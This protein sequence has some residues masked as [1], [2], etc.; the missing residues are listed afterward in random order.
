M[1]I[2]KSFWLNILFDT[3]LLTTLVIICFALGMIVEPDVFHK[4]FFATELIRNPPSEL[5]NK[6]Y[7]WDVEHYAALTLSNQCSAFYP[8]FPWLIRQLFNPQS[9]IEAAHILKIASGSISL[10][11]I[12]VTIAVFKIIIFRHKFAY[13]VCILFLL[14]PMSIFRFIGYTEGIF[15]V[16]S[17]IFI[18][19]M[20]FYMESSKNK[21]VY[22]VFLMFL[23]CLMSLTRPIL[24]QFIFAASLS[25]I[26][27]K[28]VSGSFSNFRDKFLEIKLTI[29][30]VF[31]SI[32]G[33]AIY[34]ISC[35]SSRGD[36]FA[37][38]S[39]QKLWDKKLGIHLELLLLPKS[40]L[41]DIWGLYY[42]W[43]LWFLILAFVYWQKYRLVSD[44]RALSNSILNF[45]MLLY[46]PLL[47]LTYLWLNW[48]KKTQQDL[49]NILD[50]QAILMVEN[51]YLFWFCLYFSVSQSTIVFFTQDRLNSLARYVFGVPFF[52]ITLGYVCCCIPIKKSEQLLYLFAIISAIA[53]I[54]QWIGY[55]R[56]L[57][58]G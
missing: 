42:P 12:P 48:R 11:F 38:F 35:L 29:G 50:S 39:D 45:L 8:L 5:P 56:D 3:F 2:N 21:N 10:L 15:T 26:T 9:K 53:A 46:P 18:L 43:M 57:W 25:L 23:T 32:V 27:L 36:F 51:N 7:Y 31:A 14:N 30:L 40:P 28:I 58:L 47:C 24:T 6:S 19:T 13:L 20:W 52:F 22:L 33:Y 44:F 41:F 16:F 17:L 4:Y 1:S 34:G 37:P 55:G 54:Q 49:E